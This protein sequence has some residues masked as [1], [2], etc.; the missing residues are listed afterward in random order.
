MG[1]LSDAFPKI[2]P[3]TALERHRP[4]TG[5]Y[6]GA[7]HSTLRLQRRRRMAQMGSAHVKVAG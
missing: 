5:S 3:E 2:G 4:T 6:R 1:A 7:P